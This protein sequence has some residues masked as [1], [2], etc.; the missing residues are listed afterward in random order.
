M[1]PSSMT[2]E[3]TASPLRARMIE[4]MKLAGLAAT[5]REVY[6][7]A[8]RSLAKRC[9]RSPELLAEEE[10]RRYLTL[11]QGGQ[12]SLERRPHVNRIGSTL[13]NLHHFATCIGHRCIGSARTC[14]G[15]CGGRRAGGIRHEAIIVRRGGGCDTVDRAAGP[16]TSSGE[17]GSA[18]GEYGPA[19][20]LFVP[21]DA[22]FALTSHTLGA[23]YG[24]S[25]CAA[26][27]LGAAGQ[28]GRPI[29]PAGARPPGRRRDPAPQ[30]A[31]RRE[32][33]IE[34]TSRRLGKTERNS[35]LSSRYEPNPISAV[36]SVAGSPRRPVPSIALL[37]R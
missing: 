13:C 29:E 33:D 5:T 34:M 21:V 9:N 32:G 3:Q 25:S 31:G 20:R 26:S 23:S 30:N 19:E 1:V 11:T 14:R 2:K 7:Q 8:V 28:R 12:D 24:A 15:S 6:L 22:T 4:D 36:A 18:S 37:P 10:V 27:R 16:G 17:Y 35:Q